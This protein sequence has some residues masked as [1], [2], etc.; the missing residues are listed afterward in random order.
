MWSVIVSL[1]LVS[2]VSAEYFECHSDEIDKTRNAVQNLWPNTQ[3]YY[4]LSSELSDKE[5]SNVRSALAVFNEKTCLKF[6][7]VEESSPLHYVYYNKS[8]GCQSH[9]GYNPFHKPH[10][11]HVNEYCLS[12]TG[13]IQHETLH[14]LGLHHEQKRQD[15]DQ[16]VI[17][18]WAN[19][20]HGQAYN[21]QIERGTT[22]FGVPYD[23]NSVMH[24]YKNAFA[25]DRRIPTIYAKVNGKP[26]EREMGN[27][28]GPSEG[29]LI[30]IRKMYNC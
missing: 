2:I 11:V 19:I 8:N 5:K 14:A 17:I 6:E 10:V 22:S 21:F 23:L 25:K 27:L 1:G 28:L 3:M 15:R 26:V 20:E 7:E 24:Y 30:K 9:V 12:H 18:N 29:D 13:I 4:H 16:H